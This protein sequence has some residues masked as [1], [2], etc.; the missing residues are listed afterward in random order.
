VALEVPEYGLLYSI[1]PR[2]PI[3]ELHEITYTL[4]P[5][6]GWQKYKLEGILVTTDVLRKIAKTFKKMKRLQHMKN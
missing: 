5:W 2:D 3:N 6:P 4:Y 1:A